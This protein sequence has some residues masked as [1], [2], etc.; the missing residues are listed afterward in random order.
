MAEQRSVVV[1][2]SLGKMYKGLVDVPNETYRTTDLFNS[3]SIY[4]RDSTQKCFENAVLFRDVKMVIGGSAISVK[5]DQ[6]QIKLSEILYF[7]DDLEKISDEK[8]KMRATSM[9]R[10]SKEESQSVDIITT[11]VANSFYHLTGTF[12]GLFKK[13]SNDRFIPLTDVKLTE[14]YHK[15][16]KW[17]QRQVQLPHKFIGVSTRHIEAMRIR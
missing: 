2:S 15:G 16:D 10:K 12:F 13:K 14:I 9:T 8:E 6:L 11:E 4:W 1:V 5:F 3:A 7:Y 17:F